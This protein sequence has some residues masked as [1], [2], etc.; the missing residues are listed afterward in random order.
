MLGAISGF[1]PLAMLGGMAA[2]KAI[3]AIGGIFAPD[4]PRCRPA[5]CSS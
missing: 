2:N 3:D 1:N 4:A 5:S